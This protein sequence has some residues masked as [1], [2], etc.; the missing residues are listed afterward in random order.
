MRARW[1]RRRIDASSRVTELALRAQR[2]LDGGTSRLGDARE[3]DG[4]GGSQPI[5]Q[6]SQS[7]SSV[8]T[9]SGFVSSRLI[10]SSADSIGFSARAGG[11]RRGGIVGDG[12]KAIAFCTRSTA[13][14][15]SELAERLGGSP[16][17][18][19]VSR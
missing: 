15:R 12:A 6:T 5:A 13:T 17:K 7:N 9:H 2:A 10:T 14:A 3:S 16:P 11:P 4:V 1:P 8:R 18:S 19:R